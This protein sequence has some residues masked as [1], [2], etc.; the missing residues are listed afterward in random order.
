MRDYGKTVKK[1]K[2]TVVPT[3]DLTELFHH[4]L[5]YGIAHNELQRI[6]DQP[7]GDAR[8]VLNDGKECHFDV[9]AGYVKVMAECMQHFSHTLASLNHDFSGDAVLHNDKNHRKNQ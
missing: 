6:R 5:D 3:V 1:S 4:E 7:S 8:R 9:L 2:L